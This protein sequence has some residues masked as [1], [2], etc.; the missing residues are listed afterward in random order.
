MLP[1]VVFSPGENVELDETETFEDLGHFGAFVG[2]D[3]AAV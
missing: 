3:G 1:S 2:V